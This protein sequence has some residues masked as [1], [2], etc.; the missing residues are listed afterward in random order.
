MSALV[1]GV[2][3]V[4]S[5]RGRSKAR[6][7]IGPMSNQRI[8]VYDSGSSLGNPLSMLRAMW[9]DLLASRELAY[10]LAERDIKAQY[11]QAFLGILWAFFLPLANTITW[12]FLS[13]TGIVRTGETGI[14]YPVYVFVGTMLWAIFMDALGSPLQQVNASK[15]ML[16]KLNFPR[17]AL[18]VSGLYQTLFNG[19]IKIALAL[20][21]MLLLGVWPSWTLILFPVA[22]ISLLLVGTAIGLLL[23]PIGVLY[24]DIGRALP[25]VLQFAMYITPVVF[26]MP[27]DGWTTTLFQWNPLTYL[28][29]V[30][31]D[32]IT[33]QATS[34][35]VPFLVING[36]AVVVLL[37]AWM[38][39]RIAMPILI[40]RMGG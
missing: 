12:V 13:H 27:K 17:E 4:F 37:L 5:L 29:V 10:R 18:I 35:L 24:T 22:I 19:G 14:P 30:G 2:R 16:S 6:Q 28:I 8:T 21:A 31:R 15:G 40:E 9:E 11:R 34:F 38:A 7:E 32:W 36:I 33:G 25:L 39:Y 20:G 23:T 26:P 3:W 1:D